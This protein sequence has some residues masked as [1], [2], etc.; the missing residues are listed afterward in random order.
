MSM[1]TEENGWVNT[2][3]GQNPALLARARQILASTL[4]ATL[5]TS[6]PAG[7]PWAAPLFFVY[8]ADWNLYWSSAI[9]ARHSQDLAASGG[10]A[11]IAVYST[12][13]AVG[14]GQGLYLVG[15]AAA[16]EPEAVAQIVPLFDRRSPLEQHR[17]PADYLGPSPRRIYRFQPEAVWMTGDRLPVSETVLVDTRV[18]L[19][20]ASLVG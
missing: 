1:A 12:D 5:A 9:A 7:L 8:D 17:S 11:A 2:A 10:R 3:D 13:R 6:S 14:K 18:Q 15:R 20:L 19:D 4:Y 16:V